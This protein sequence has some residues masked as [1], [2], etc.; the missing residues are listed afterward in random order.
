VVRRLALGEAAGALRLDAAA[1]W[2]FREWEAEIETLLAEGGELEMM[3]DW[4]GKLAGATLRIVATLH[5]VEHADGDPLATSIGAATIAAAVRIA[6]YLMPHAEAVLTLMSA[7]DDDG[8]DDARYLLRWIE[9][10]GLRTFSKRDAH[11]H[12]K[13]RFSK[14]DAL[15]AALGELIA[16]G[17]I[18]PLPTEAPR[19]GRPASPRYE[20]N[21]VVCNVEGSKSAPTIPR[22]A[23]TKAQNRVLGI[24]GALWRF[25]LSRWRRA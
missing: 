15:D 19:P 6:R 17:Y 23:A 25:R 20:V 21:P 22:T 7:R 14:A 10:H 18:R 12:G 16:R 24:S 2:A 13:R 1:Q 9:R 4:G 5:A 11:Q 8:D 3:R